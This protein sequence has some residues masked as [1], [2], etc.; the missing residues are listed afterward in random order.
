MKRLFEM[1]WRLAIFRRVAPWIARLSVP[2]P[3][4]ARLAS[5]SCDRPLTWRERMRM[6]LHYL[7]CDWCRRYNG[8]LRALHDWAPQLA[9][10]APQWKRRRMPEEVRL[11]LK[12]RL[13]GDAS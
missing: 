2:C 13:H 12:E 1:R 7:I 4:I 8:Q 5:A 11:R 9:E 3:E 6:R 10:R